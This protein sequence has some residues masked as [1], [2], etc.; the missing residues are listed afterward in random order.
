MRASVSFL[1]GL[2][3][4]KIAIEIGKDCKRRYLKCDQRS[5]SSDLAVCSDW[6]SAIEE[7]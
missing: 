2:D 4:E 7:L 1:K 5:K 6:K 3:A